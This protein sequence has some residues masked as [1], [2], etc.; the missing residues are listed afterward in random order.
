MHQQTQLLY[1]CRTH[2]H[3]SPLDQNSDE[4]IFIFRVKNK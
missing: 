1:S 2:L 4:Y 3:S